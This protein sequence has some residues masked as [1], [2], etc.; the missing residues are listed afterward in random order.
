MKGKLLNLVLVVTSLIGYLEWG[1]DNKS[2]L[3]E[4]VFEL[5]KKML[6]DPISAV[7][8]FTLIPLFGQILIL[9][10][11]FQ[12]APNRKLTY[13]AISCIG[14]LLVFMFFIGIIGLNLKILV[15]TVPFIVVALLTIKHQRSIYNEN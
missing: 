14:L 10:T 12:K 13:L 7:H 1:K 8:P 3:I 6:I 15:S 4:A 2:F 11:L 9:I 5:L